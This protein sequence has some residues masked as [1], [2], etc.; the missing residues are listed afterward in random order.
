MRE[1]E[2]PWTVVYIFRISCIQNILPWIIKIQIDYSLT[3]LLR[4]EILEEN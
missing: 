2:K 4:F 3:Q 1:I